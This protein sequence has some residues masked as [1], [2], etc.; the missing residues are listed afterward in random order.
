MAET[1]VFKQIRRVSVAD[2]ERLR[3]VR[4]R[5]LATDPHAFLESLE[6]ARRLPEAHW[7]DRA[8]PSEIQVT[9]VEE[10]DGSFTAMVGAFTD[11]YAYVLSRA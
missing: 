9:F 8:T 11:F 3:D 4:L 1:D 5:A 10:R 2:W 6:H 7:R